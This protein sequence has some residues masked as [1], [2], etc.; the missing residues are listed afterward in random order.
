[1]SNNIIQKSFAA[2]ELAPSLLARTDLAKYHTGAATLRNFFVDYRSG[3]SS[4][5]GTKFIMQALDSSKPVRLI[6]FQYST[7]ATYILEFGDFY[8]RFISEGATV[9]EAGF[10]ITGATAAF[11][12]VLTVVGN[13][14]VNDDWIFVTGVGGMTRLN[15]RFYKV[16]VAGN[17]VTLFDVNGR[18]IDA[19]TFTAYTS[20]GTASRVYKIVS[21]YAAEDL[22][23]LKYIQSAQVMTLTHP[24]YQARDLTLT[25]ATNWTLTAVTTGVNVDPPTAVTPTASTGGTVN[26]A[27]V[28]TSVDAEGNESA[29]STSGATTSVNIATTAGSIRVTFTPPAAGN[30]PSYYNVYKAEP[31]Y[32][33]A[34]PV[35]ASY[36]FVG[37][38]TGTTFD[39][40]NIV[41]DFSQQPPIVEDPFSGTNYPGCASYFS[42]RLWYGG[43]TANPLTLYASQPGLYD[44]FNTSFPSQEDDALTETLVSTQVN[45]VRWM[46]PM[47][48][49]LVVGTAKGAWLVNGGSAGAQVSVSTATATPQAYNG[50]SNVQPIVVNND[51][52]HV[53]DKGAIVRDLSFNIYASIYT[54][55]DIS[56]LS[57]HLFFQYQINEWAYAEEPFKIIWAVRNDGTLLS[58]TYVKEQEL[59]GWARHDTK[60]QFQSVASITEGQVD[61]VYV[62]VKRYLTGLWIKTIERMA[63]RAFLYGAEDAW[64]VDCGLA[65]TLPTPAAGLVASA[66]T[67][68]VTF[69]ADSGVFASTDVG[70][71]LRMGGGIAT[72]TG[73][74][75]ASII[76]G[77]LTKDITSIVPDD[78]DEMPLPATSGEWSLAAPSITFTGFDY[79][80][81]S[82]VSVLA[83]GGVVYTTIENGTLTLPN[84]A[85]KVVGGLGFQ[86]QLQTMYLDIQGE[87]GTVQGKRKK[88]SALT[89]RC[90]ESRGLKAGRTFERMVNIKELNRAV[91]LGN[92]IPLITGD[93]RVIMDQ[94]WDVPGQICLQQNDPLPVTVLGVIPEIEIGDK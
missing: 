77:T 9:V 86:A 67:G 6:P 81:G 63:D 64:S 5:P 53:Q 41:P 29:V 1:M 50:A 19:R 22:A 79:L 27:Y 37:F 17:A 72:I 73:Y 49:G 92:P 23:L 84:A 11:P 35:G 87:G 10:A 26:Y 40:T 61:A 68:S 20:G 3:A 16:Q 46:I 25:A 57:N 12:S 24:D 58:L 69:T 15:N 56:V 43:A 65:S 71:V 31:S 80:E 33:G 13:S 91:V 28:V 93:E 39:D 78:D 32:S 94:L 18:A 88:V 45:A 14:W 8:I 83:D 2:G 90:M 89:V 42:Q 4:R 47:Q 85:T 36:G 48:T 51:I 66:S 82:A 38:C 54:G 75:S 52:L 55:T 34:V 7:T 62:V 70:S 76:S 44:N 74:T 60:G 30:T 59:Y 21:P